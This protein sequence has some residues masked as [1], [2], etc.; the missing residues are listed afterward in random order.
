MVLQ[1]WKWVG[2][3]IL[4]VV[5]VANKSKGLLAFPSLLPSLSRQLFVNL[6]Q[7]GR[8]LCLDSSSQPPNNTATSELR[9]RRSNRPKSR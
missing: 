5:A 6:L 1:S 9:G 8:I 4:F 3:L 2:G 7:Q